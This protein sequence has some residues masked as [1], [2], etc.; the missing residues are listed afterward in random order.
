MR[1]IHQSLQG[2]ANHT[3][4]TPLVVMGVRVGVSGC[5]SRW[6]I[7][8]SDG[9]AMSNAITLSNSDPEAAAPAPPPRKKFRRTALRVGHSLSERPAAI[10]VDVDAASS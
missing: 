2:I 9:D 7:D 1:R 4:G 10:V 5:G 6:A 8:A 3:H